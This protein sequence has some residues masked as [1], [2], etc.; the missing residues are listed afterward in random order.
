MILH[1]NSQCQDHKGTYGQFRAPA[2]DNGAE[3]DR[4]I[5]ERW[6]FRNYFKCVH[7]FKG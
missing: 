6:Y 4:Q 3:L 5:D 2:G 1:E 7:D